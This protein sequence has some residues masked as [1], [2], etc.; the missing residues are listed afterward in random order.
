MGDLQKWIEAVRDYAV[1]YVIWLFQ[2]AGHPSYAAEQA[3]SFSIK[4]SPAQ[5]NIPVFILIS[6]LIG[7]TV[8]LLV[9]NRPPMKDR[10]QV[11]VTVAL[12][13][14][15]IS[16]LVHFFC[17]LMQGRGSLTGTV[18]TM[19]QV[20]AM[21]YVF[22]YFI[23]LLISAAAIVI[24]WVRFELIKI[25]FSK[26]GDILLSLQFLMLLVY[27]PLSVGSVHGFRAVRRVVIGV[28]AAACASGLG[29]LVLAMGGC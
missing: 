21:V 22:S 29:S 6:I 7:A 28:T 9:P 4:K 24:P 16:T 15:L 3:A 19:V 27:V 2:V 23:V 14:L 11:A 1:D 25:G 20:L 17:R 26:P 13:W 8:G 5:A 12:L 18:V 10:A